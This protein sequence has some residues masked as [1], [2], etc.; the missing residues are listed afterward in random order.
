MLGLLN[1]SE[2]VS[3]CSGVILLLLILPV[4][5]PVI[6]AAMVWEAVDRGF[7][8]GFVDSG[9]E[10]SGL[11]LGK[12][13][14]W[15]NEW[16]KPFNSQFVRKPEDAYMVNCIVMY[17]A[18]IPMMFGACFWYTQAHGLS[19]PLWFC[20]HLFRIGPYFMNFAYVYTL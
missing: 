19:L 3:F 6:F 18:A 7:E 11:I 5:G 2:H 12:I 14:P 9:K 4:L 15:V 13:S 17:G 8:G 20:Y 10:L 16:T 1:T